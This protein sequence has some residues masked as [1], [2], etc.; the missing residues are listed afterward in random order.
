[1]HASKMS[2]RAFLLAT[3]SLAAA[4]AA[5]G[6]QA[7]AFPPTHGDE[8][9]AQSVDSSQINVT[10]A[11]VPYDVCIIGSGP[12]GSVLGR[13]LVNQGL[14][15]VILESGIA[16]QNEEYDPRLPSLDV[17][18]SI[19]PVDYPLASTR[20]RGLGGTSTLWTGRCSRMHPLDFEPYPHNAYTPADAPWPISY[21]D[22]EPYY[23][24]AEETLHV[25]GAPLSEYHAPRQKSL[26]IRSRYDYSPLQALMMPIGITLDEPPTSTGQHQ[27]GPVRAALDIMPGFLASP[28]ATLRTGLTATKLLTD[29]DG[30]ITGVV[31]QNLE[32]ETETIRAHKYVIAC[33]GVES[34]RLLL[35]SRSEAFPNGIGNN[36]DLV[37]RYFMEHFHQNFRGTIPNQTTTSKFARTHQ[38]YDQLKLE[39][40]GSII[41]TFA[42]RN[43]KEHNLEI[44]AS[45]EMLPVPQNRIT[46]SEEN[47][48]YFGNPGVDLWLEHPAK[49][50]ETAER[51]RK[52]VREI[53]AD[54][55]GKDVYELAATG[56]DW[57][58][59]HIGTC[60]MG[61]DPATSVVDAHLRVHESPNLYV[62]SSAVFVTGGPGHPTV[63]ITALAHRLA[64]HLVATQDA[65]MPI[66]YESA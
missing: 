16:L 57:G 4:T 37:G 41:L 10:E 24:R 17:Y 61:N 46:L 48:D 7:W 51:V 63:A 19:G 11:D 39:G 6:S 12:A 27:A 40:L 18:R 2:R 29:F 58:H 3:A 65:E 9:A 38:F 54:L 21:A 1:M 32:R 66:T 50:V 55:G 62:L 60:R 28:Q 64:E 53:Y 23:D 59:H 33:G 26:P 44:A 56:H 52:V 42:W 13:D 14:R 45:V 15:T 34:A 22:L 20:L 30:R 43:R 8:A 5:I 25:R 31:V 49:D 36:N 35:L 47:V